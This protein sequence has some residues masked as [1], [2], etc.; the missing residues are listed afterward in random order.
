MEGDIKMEILF[1]NPIYKDYIWGGKRLKEEFNKKTPYDITAESWEISANEN[2]KTIIK[3]GELKGKDLKEIYEN[4]KYKGDIFG[5]K[6]LKLDKFPLLIKFIDAKQNLSVQ[7]HPN[8]E[9]A[10]QN[11]NDS[12]KTEMWYIIDCKREGKLICGTKDIKS[13]KE[14]EKIIKS[15]DIKNYLQY[16]DIEK[17]DSIYIP[18]G[19]IHAILADTLICEIQQNSNL[20]Y[21]VYD[22]DRIDSFGNKRQLHI[23]KAID[24][25][26]FNSETKKVKS[27]NK[28]VQNLVNSEYFKVDRI[29][30]DGE[31]QDK[32]SIE[33]FYCINVIEG[34]GKIINNTNTFK[35][36]KGDS[37][38][39]PATLGDY[40]IVGNL[41]ILKSYI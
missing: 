6:C 37:F 12:G 30:I 40:K 19:T 39:V 32:S 2:G 41:T 17:G 34:T 7:V 3:N 29:K 38:V 1:C 13:K 31:Y 27:E 25:I 24:V 8:D 4:K 9:Y 15:G 11:E 35:I 22:W 18:S 20:T 28:T 21:R 23:E 36:Q 5:T 16:I 33:T 10:K 26:D 14:L